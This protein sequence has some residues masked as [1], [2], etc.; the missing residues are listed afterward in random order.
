MQKNFFIVNFLFD[1]ATRLAIELKDIEL[2][3]KL[4]VRIS[5]NSS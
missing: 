2:R 4:E 5:F 1:R 3:A